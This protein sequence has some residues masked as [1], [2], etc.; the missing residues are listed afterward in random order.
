MRAQ[1]STAPSSSA[2]SSGSRSPAVS[3]RVDV[4]GASQGSVSKVDVRSSMPSL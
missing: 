4:G 2:T 3:Q 1:P